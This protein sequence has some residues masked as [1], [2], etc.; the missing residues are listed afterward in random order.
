MPKRIRST[1]RTSTG[2]G[3]TVI[4]TPSGIDV[5]Y[6]SEGESDS[7]PRMKAV[8]E[9]QGESDSQLGSLR[10][11][12]RS[13]AASQTDVALLDVTAVWESEAENE[14]GATMDIRNL[15]CTDDAWT[16][17][18]NPNANH[19]SDPDLSIQ[20]GVIAVQN[21]ARAYFLFDLSG[22]SPNWT[23]GAT[24]VMTFECHLSPPAVDVLAT[25]TF[26]AEVFDTQPWDESTLTWNNQPDHSEVIAEYEYALLTG[27]HTASIQLDWTP[28]QIVGK[29]LSIYA[30][31]EALV[32]V[33]GTFTIRSRENALGPH[34]NLSFSVQI[35]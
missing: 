23:T 22:M 12:L 20:Q 8:L 35:P 25:A 18:G 33:V 6:G 11:V 21:G 29:Y 10:A 17:E 19:G 2:G 16:D 7:E 3:D 28:S 26:H 15:R 32:A 13:E 4:V 5:V 31:F 27:P 34:P 9:S 30:T 1:N 24:P 14:T